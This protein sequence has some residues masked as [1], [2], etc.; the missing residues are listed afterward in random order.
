MAILESV[1]SHHAWRCDNCIVSRSDISVGACVT[2]LWQK[3]PWWSVTSTW[4]PVRTFAPFAAMF[5]N[6]KSITE[7]CPIESSLVGTLGSLHI[8]SLLP[9]IHLRVSLVLGHAV[10][11]PSSQS[12]CLIFQS[13]V[14][15]IGFVW[16]I[17]TLASLSMVHSAC[18]CSPRAFWL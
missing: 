10:L 6:V 15:I 13:L 1:P 7:V 12:G 3:Q 16:L 18:W 5:L 9:L 4:C 2:Q 17:V 8:T 11:T 14:I